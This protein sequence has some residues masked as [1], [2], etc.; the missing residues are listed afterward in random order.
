MERKKKMLMKIEMEE[1]WGSFAVSFHLVCFL[2]FIVFS[3][4]FFWLEFRCSFLYV[5]GVFL[6]DRVF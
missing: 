4:L 1:K 3:L 2:L 5:S 6:K